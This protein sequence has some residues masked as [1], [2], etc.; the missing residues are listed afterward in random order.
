MTKRRLMK[1][2]LSVMNV[3]ELYKIH[4][5]AVH[6][7]EGADQPPKVSHHAGAAAPPVVDHIYH[8]LASEHRPSGAFL[9]YPTWNEVMSDNFGGSMP[10]E[11]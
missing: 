9:F 7:A 4:Q 6:P 10:A 1:R 11:F 2:N 3:V 8:N 5:Q